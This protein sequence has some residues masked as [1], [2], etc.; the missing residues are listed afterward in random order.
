MVETTIENGAESPAVVERE[1]EDKEDS[2]TDVAEQPTTTTAAP[3]PS[4]SSPQQ[5]DK[6]E[7]SNEE[8]TKEE[9][10]QGDQTET[11]AEE[12]PEKKDSPEEN[13]DN[14]A[15]AETASTEKEGENPTETSPV[16]ES[17]NGA[18][19]VKTEDNKEKKDDAKAETKEKLEDEEKQKSQENQSLA[20]GPVVS[21]TK[22]TRPPYKYDPE[23]V[24]LRFLFANRDGLT[25]TVEC[26]PGDTVGEVKGQLL[27]VWPEDLPDCSGGDQLRL[28]CMGKGML[29]PDSRT[30]EDC[31]VP[32]FKT[33]PTPVNVSVRPKTDVV[34]SSKSG[35][36]V[37]NRGSSSVGASS[38]RA[39]EQTGQGCGCVI[40]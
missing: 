38:G 30:L 14:E 23:K 7:E 17:T 9:Q 20:S 8:A 11:A 5:E 2:C 12:N 1:A 27:S 6:P 21:S 32:V 25:V 3:V 22:R 36:D 4:E 39:A 31:Q 24:T 26:K 37:G 35:K 34:E 40:L 29:M 19:T 16:A 18:E 10:E 13:E 28:I 33:H 15:K